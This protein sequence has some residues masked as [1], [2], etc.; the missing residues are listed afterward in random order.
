VFGSILNRMIFLELL[1]V[2]AMA[3]IGITGLLLLAGVVSEASKEGLAPHQIL[4]IIPLIIP[5]TLPYTIPATTLFASCVIYGRLAHDNEILAIKSAGVNVMRVIAPGLFL[6]L[7]M[8][9]VTFA[10][11]YS[12]IPTTHH[13]LRSLF[14]NDVEG[15]LYSMLQRD[16][17]FKNPR[18]D[19][20]IRVHHV[21]GRKLIDVYFMHKDRSVK[22]S[23]DVIANAQEAELQ[24]EPKNNKINVRMRYCVVWSKN[25]TPMQLD[26]HV[27]SVD[28]PQELFKMDRMRPSDLTWD[29]LF[30]AQAK[31]LQDIDKLAVD[32]AAQAAMEMKDSPPD[33]LHVHVKNLAAIK[34]H[35]QAE[36]R[37]IEMELQRRPALALGCFCFV[38]VG[39]PVGIWFSR[40]DYLSAFVTC[41]LPIV[42]LYY[43][44]LLFGMNVAKSGSPLMVAAIWVPN[45]VIGV[46]ALGLYQR[47]MRN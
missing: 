15:L 39:C 43:P 29:E 25:N 14:L 2:F 40:S 30:T 3:L 26:S 24:W 11:Y 9:A 27:E 1:K 17:C 35:K 19:Y 32:V 4:A 47:L 5:S 36:Y 10:I 38:L 12:L 20:E 6:G 41:F 28:L 42:L 18:V 44:L 33:N 8:A 31:L 23:Y 21:Q 37:E 7:L 46:I 22:D 45:A 13:L 16:G 34:K